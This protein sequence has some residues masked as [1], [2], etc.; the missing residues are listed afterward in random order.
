M[1]I[2]LFLDRFHVQ[3]AARAQLH[4]LEDFD[5]WLEITHAA[6]VTAAGAIHAL[7]PLCGVAASAAPLQRSA[8][9]LEVL[10]ATC[11][12]SAPP[13]QDVVAHCE[14]AFA[15]MCNML[16]ASCDFGSL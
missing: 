2:S 16:R 8:A 12:R 7:V 5:S 9:A 10:R 11:T 14:A 1:Q 6:A 3:Q 13:S 4:P 15:D